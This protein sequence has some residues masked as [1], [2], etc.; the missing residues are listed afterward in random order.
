[1]AWNAERHEVAEITR[2]AFAEVVKMVSSSV[3]D[4]CIAMETLVALNR[5][6]VA[7]GFPMRVRTW[8][9]HE[10][11]HPIPCRTAGRLGSF[12][13]EVASVV[14]LRVCSEPPSRGLLYRRE[15]RV[16]LA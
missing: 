5:L 11:R 16:P 13:A 6:S 7:L 12:V 15:P 9:G 8:A 3:L 14:D 1:M 4:Y 2:A 10:Q